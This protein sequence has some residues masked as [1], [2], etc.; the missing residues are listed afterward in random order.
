MTRFG[1]GTLALLW[2]VMAVTTRAEQELDLLA[3]VGDVRPG[4]MEGFSHEQPP[5]NSA[6][7][8]PPPPSAGSPGQQADTAANEAAQAYRDTA[9]WQLA[10]RDANLK[11]P[12]AASIFECAAQVSITEAGTPVLYRLLQRTLTDFGLATYPAKN[13]YQRPAG[14]FSSM[15]SQSALPKTRSYWLRTALTPVAT[16]PL[17]GAGLWCC[18][19]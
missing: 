12:E 2:A 18:R 19:N 6:A 14:P 11:F 13:A 16:V 5:L 3:P 4:L 10:A 7:F 15:S 1:R 8:V 9:R 17:A